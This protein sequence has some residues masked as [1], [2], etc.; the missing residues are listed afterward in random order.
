MQPNAFLNKPVAPTDAELSAEIGKSKTLWD[1]LLSD[2]VADGLATNWEW[3]S[4]SRKAGWS[5]RAKRD[6]RTILY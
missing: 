1:R 6:E 5:V 4:Y 3:H 2:L